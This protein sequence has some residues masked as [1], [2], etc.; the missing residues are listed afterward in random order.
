[1]SFY[2]LFSCSKACKLFGDECV[3]G[4]DVFL[5]SHTFYLVVI[6]FVSLWVVKLN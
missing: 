1:M 5:Y 4:V 6:L 3:C 2:S